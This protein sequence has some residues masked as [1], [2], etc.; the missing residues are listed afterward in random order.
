[1]LHGAELISF[2]NSLLVTG[3]QFSKVGV[4]LDGMLYDGV[5]M[6]DAQPES[7]LSLKMRQNHLLCEHRCRHS[8]AHPVRFEVSATAVV[9]C[10]GM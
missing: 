9:C 1:M 2:L 10:H 6:V 8:Q 3:V 7:T 4:D 5:V